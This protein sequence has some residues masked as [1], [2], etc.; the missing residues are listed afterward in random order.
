MLAEPSTI[1]TESNCFGC[2]QSNPIGLRLQF[3]LH[4]NVL[5]TRVILGANYESFPGVVHGGIIASIMDE[6]LAQA[7]YRCTQV[8]AFT[9]GL[10]VRYGQPMRTGTEHLA[11]A[12]VTR[13]DDI[14]L[15]AAGRLE[16]SGGELV[17]AAEGTF[18]LLTDDMLGHLNQ[19][20]P[21]EL[22]CALRASNEPLTER[23]TKN[24]HSSGNP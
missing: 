16:L 11:Y 14:S 9:T 1:Q 20:L 3:G 12:E 18:C 6:V 10:R 13:K 23:Q 8:S 15:Q 17:A 7:V 19:Q 21:A 22:T 2:A 5:A 4:G 24:G